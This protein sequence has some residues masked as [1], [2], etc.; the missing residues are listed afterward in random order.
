[1]SGAITPASRMRWRISG[2]AA[3]ASGMFTVIRTIS[4]PA[5]ASA[6]HCAAVPAASVVSVLV[7]DCT[8]TGAPPPTCTAPGPLPT[9]TPT[10]RCT[11][12]TDI[13]TPAPPLRSAAVGPEPSVRKD[14]E[15]DEV[16]DDR[17]RLGR[18]IDE[19]EAGYVGDVVALDHGAAVH[20]A[21]AHRDDLVVQGQPQVVDVRGGQRNGRDQR[22]AAGTQLLDRHRLVERQDVPLELTEQID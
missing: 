4:E 1:M 17:H 18:R 16:L 21:G 11:R 5:S 19:G 10:V 13:R 3:A 15:A 7:I 12:T 9:R 6:M 2:T 14:V 8:T 22:E 20:D